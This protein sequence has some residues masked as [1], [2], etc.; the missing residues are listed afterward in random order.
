MLL[1]LSFKEGLGHRYCTQLNY[2]LGTP[3]V[4]VISSRS[5]RDIQT[6]FIEGTADNPE[7]ENYAQ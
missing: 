6:R 2:S 1:I 4:D 5:D 7:T 3:R